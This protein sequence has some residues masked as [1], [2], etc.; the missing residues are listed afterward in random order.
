MHGSQYSKVE[1]EVLDVDIRLRLGWERALNVLLGVPDVVDCV[2]KLE[3][4]PT[5][6]DMSTVEECVRLWAVYK[7]RWRLRMDNRACTHVGKQR[8][9]GCGVLDLDVHLA[10]DLMMSVDVN[11]YVCDEVGVVQPT[12]VYVV[13]KWDQEQNGWHQY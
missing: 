8:F 9:L 10:D 5:G 13:S 4:G 7:W 2:G 3:I 11:T 1:K 6:Y 12:S